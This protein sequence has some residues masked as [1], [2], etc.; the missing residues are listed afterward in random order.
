M[1]II[2]IL[3]GGQLLGILGMLLAVPLATVVRTAAKEIYYGY[4]NYKIIH[5]NR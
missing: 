5:V 1:I 4:K 3:L 2:L